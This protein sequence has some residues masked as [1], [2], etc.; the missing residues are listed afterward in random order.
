MIVKRMGVFLVSACAA[1]I[2]GCSG[3]DMA[4]A[5][6]FL[7]S[8]DYLRARKLY[9]RILKHNPKNYAARYG[10][11][12]TYSAEAIHKTELGMAEPLDWYPAVYHLNLAANLRERSDVHATLAVLHYN[13]ATMYRREGDTE[14]ALERLEQAVT[15]DST[16]LKA[17]NLLG[18][19]Y[20]QD[21]Y[22]EDAARCYER[23][24]SI[25]PQYAMAHFNLGAVDWALGNYESAYNRFQVADS[26]S[27]GNEY[28]ES[29]LERARARVGENSD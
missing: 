9:E 22:M 16:L 27:P 5:N 13:L 25:S 17:V 7:E 2:V 8:G 21:G 6:E 12:M 23:V 15:Y 24:V 14:S 4:T 11:G 1:M 26:L 29:W 28:F 19:L 3:A 20:H 10:M 18:T